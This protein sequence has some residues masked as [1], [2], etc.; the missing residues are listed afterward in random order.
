[1]LDRL[2]RTPSAPDAKLLKL[3]RR[4]RRALSAPGLGSRIVLER[5]GERPV[6]DRPAGTG[7]RVRGTG[8]RARC[9]VELI[10]W[11]FP[12]GKEEEGGMF[13]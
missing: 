7:E 13:A 1:M 4:S 3:L 6:G 11:I 8:E 10:V 9:M 5:P 12:G 2:L